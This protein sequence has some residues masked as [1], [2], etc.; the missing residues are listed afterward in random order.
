MDWTAL[1]L[2]TFLITL[3]EGVEAALVVGIVLAY[4]S[5]AGKTD[6]NAWIYFGIIAGILSSVLVGGFFNASIWAI[7]QQSQGAALKP[8]MEAMFGAI[9]I[10][11]LSWMLLWMTQQ[12]KALKGNIEGNVL[13]AIQQEAGAGWAVFGIVFSAVLREGFETVVFVAAQ[14]N[15]GW[16]PA[17]GAVF[18][19]LGAT[20]IGF[21]L[22]R[23]GV[24]I[25]LKQFFQVMGIF[26]L[27]IVGGLVISVL[28]HLDQG[29]VRLGL[30][31]GMLG[32]QV[33][34][35]SG[36]MSDRTFPGIIFKTLLGYRDRLYGVEAIAYVSFLLGMGSLYLRNLSP[37]PPTQIQKGPKIRVGN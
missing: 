18:G 37:K 23:W 12:A 33:W 7:S 11:L 27:L 13:S 14:S 5:K 32:P 10:G 21:G 3:R 34:D 2:P 15:Q 30:T 24:K 17:L 20:A 8:L 31:S 19:L 29:F 35:L 9:A 26:L 36:V 1:F 6:L 16:G 4:L 28:A 25:D 22:F